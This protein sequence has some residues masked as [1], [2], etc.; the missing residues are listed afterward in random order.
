[1]SMWV[2]TRR[3]EA[4]VE[5]AFAAFTDFDLV[6]ETITGIKSFEVLT[7]G[8]FEK[9]T[10]FKETRLMGKK[11]RTEEM[12]ISAFDP[13]KSYTISANSCG[14]EMHFDHRFRAEAGGT[15]FE[16]EGRMKAVSFFA[17]LTRP[18]WGLM[19]GWM[20]KCVNKDLDQ[21]IEMIEAS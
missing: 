4:P 21:M 7:D 19:S 15:V 8:P 20:R 16:M 18:F 10:R 12:E 6:S 1:M 9:G 2:V 14:C 13:G 5:K 11:E 17:K 3:I